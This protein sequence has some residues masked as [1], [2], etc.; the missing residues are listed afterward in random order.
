MNQ[1]AVSPSLAVVDGQLI[2]TSRNVAEVF[3]KRHDR[4]L[5]A[6]DNLEVSDEFSRPN[7]GVAFS[8]FK[9]MH[10]RKSSYVDDQQKPRVMYELTRNGFTLL[11]MGFTGDRAL[12]FK[13]AY[14]EAFDRMEAELL[15]QQTEAERTINVNHSH[16][17]YTA[18]PGGLDIRYTLD[19]TKVVLNP[20]KASLTVLE[21]L[22]GVQLADLCKDIPV[23]SPTSE[24][25]TRFAEAGMIGPGVGDLKFAEVYAA[26]M[27]WYVGEL[28]PADYAPTVRAMARWLREQGYE[29][30]KVGGLIRVHGVALGQE[31]VA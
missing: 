17:R 27:R 15:H 3:G 7:F 28:Y 23:D 26:F 25:F 20:G 24:P 14:I 12:E 13:V 8:E 29:L 18:A 21:R 19:L 30:R 22:T 31:V 11:A 4:I 16:W 6:I 1:S 5:R 2:T 9:K 10:F